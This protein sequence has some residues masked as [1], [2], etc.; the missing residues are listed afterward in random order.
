[1]GGDGRPGDEQTRGVCADAVLDGGRLVLVVT[2]R[3]VDELVGECAP[4][5]N[6]GEVLVQ[7]DAPAVGAPTEVPEGVRLTSMSRSAVK[8][9]GSNMCSNVVVSEDTN[10][11]PTCQVGASIVSPAVAPTRE[12]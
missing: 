5:L 7:P 2:A 3:E 10:K 9:Q 4:G 1:M 8:A 11:A 12:G 6:G